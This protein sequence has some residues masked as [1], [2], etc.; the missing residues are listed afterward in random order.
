MTPPGIR[1]RRVPHRNEAPALFCP[2][3]HA[4]DCVLSG[5]CGADSFRTGGCVSRLTPEIVD[6]Y[7][8]RICSTA[9]EPIRT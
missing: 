6:I 3:V 8:H 5:P 4:P 1:G 9:S 2:P 7:H